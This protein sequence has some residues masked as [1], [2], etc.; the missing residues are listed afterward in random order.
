MAKFLIRAGKMATIGSMI[1]Q[2]VSLI[3]NLTD[4]I[5]SNHRNPDHVNDPKDGE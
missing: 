5:A 4:H 3:A 2:A 1:L